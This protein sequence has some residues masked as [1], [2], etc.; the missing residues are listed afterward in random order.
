MHKGEIS[1]DVLSKILEDVE[2]ELKKEPE[3]APFKD[4]AYGRLAADA[5]KY[6]ADVQADHL[7]RFYMAERYLNHVGSNGAFYFTF[8]EDQVPVL[9]AVLDVVGRSYTTI[10][11]RHPLSE[12]TRVVSTLE[13]RFASA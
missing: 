1:E 6:L 5:I 12:L 8:G 7:Y 9:R 10:C 2:Q 11:K 13:A 4:E 3:D